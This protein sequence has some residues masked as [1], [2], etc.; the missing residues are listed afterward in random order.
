M[1]CKVNWDRRV[2]LLSVKEYPKPIKKFYKSLLESN[3][4]GHAQK[5]DLNRLRK[6]S[7]E[8]QLCSSSYALDSK[9]QTKE[10]K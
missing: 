10:D 3:F 2:I 6:C 9:E 7:E 4:S 8:W 1:N 5:Q